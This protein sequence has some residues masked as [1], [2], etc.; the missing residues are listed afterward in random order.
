MAG[1]GALAR[2]GGMGAV[3][4][5]VGGTCWWS[6][7]KM[8][9]WEVDFPVRPGNLRAMR[10]LMIWWG[11]LVV[12]VAAPADEF[13]AAA[14]ARHG[15]AGERAAK[16]LVANMPAGDASL[17][18]EFLTE[19]LDLAFQAREQF[20]WGRQ[21]PEE[22]FHNDVL[23]YAVFDESRDPWRAELLKVAGPLVKEARTAGEAAQLLN[24]DLFKRVNVHYNTGRKR[25]NQSPKESMESGIATCSGLSILLVDACR[26][27]GV[28]ARA[29]GT[30]MWT[31]NRGNHTWVEIWDNGWHFLGAD[32]YDKEGLNRGWFTADAAKAR[33]NERIYA[34]YATTW[35]RDGLSFPLVWAP[36]SNAV[37][38]VN[39]TGRYN[40]LGAA[41]AGAAAPGGASC[42]VPGGAGWVQLGVRLFGSS[43]GERVV[44]TVEALDASGTVLASGTTKAGTA[45]MNDMPRLALK[46]GTSGTLRFTVDGE[47]R[48]MPFLVPA[49]GEPT[50]DAV[51]PA[52][53]AAPVT[54]V[55]AGAA[56][57]SKALAALRGWLAKP[58]AE[59]KLDDP[60][61]N[62]PLTREEAVKV[63]AAF[64]KDV[65][66]R[67]AAE[68]KE[69]ME[70]KVITLGDKKM[71]WLE[72]TFGTA[73]A[74]GASL[75]ISMHGGGGAPKEVND[76]QWE[77]QIKL[78]QP[79]EGIYLAP[80]A[81]T[82]NWNLWHE[83]HID[84]M[85]QRLIEDFVALRGVNPNKI[86]LMG[87]SAGGD[88][89]WQLGPRMADRFAAAS[90]MAGHPN[91]SSLLGLRNLPFAIFMGGADSAYN[92]N[93]VAAEKAAELDKLAA[94]DPGGYT[95]YSRIF[96]GS[97]HWMN[98][99]DA[100]ALPWM[101]KFQRNPW[102][103]KII[104]LQDDVT[105]ERFYWLRLAD[106]GAAKANDKIVAVI[107][108]QTVK[109]DGAVQ[110][111]MQVRLSDVLL[112]L[113]KPVSVV[114][115]GKPVGAPARVP[116][117]AAVIWQ[118]L[119]ERADPAASASAA[120]VLP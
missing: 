116:R 69:E 67:L 59:R 114:V 64:A 95:H 21:V 106:K 107:D 58:L 63:S 91:E 89:V 53:A 33:A 87:Y 13:V 68:R 94:D 23:P 46:R 84:P 60:A 102:P 45:D 30:P 11:M 81:P 98:L 119:A 5:G 36:H 72:K 9:H 24:R 118:T 12:A 54:L 74:D 71:P 4:G 103:K 92:R 32:E 19:N 38:A 1:I 50:I 56:G 100:E 47:S 49:A 101:E 83:E 62:L 44:A 26:A 117:T 66:G 80:R 93:K 96:P 111:K 10:S 110:P 105:H 90:M 6:G 57:E 48:S 76:Q 75:W 77:N 16:Y 51:W 78:Y 55:A 79:K 35:K 52:L 28:P 82:D 115:N 43:G 22:I 3:G 31:N 97:G 18:V 34:I 27:V 20:P 85:F 73:P 70:K 7:W 113:D 112:D 88:G 15:E 14:K 41:G 120:V 8:A 39:V 104:W 42:P 17:S 65:L 29:V 86:Y 40:Q 2:L 99:Q 61:L 109:I 25:P 108:G 37:A